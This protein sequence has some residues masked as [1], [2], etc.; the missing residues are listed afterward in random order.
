MGVVTPVRAT[1]DTYS[2]KWSKI[3]PDAVYPWALDLT[4]TLFRYHQEREKTRLG[5]SS[6]PGVYL[7][8]NSLI[9]PSWQ[10]TPLQT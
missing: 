10:R 3:L 9:I 6:S 7:L 1:M 2:L 4:G 5:T 8:R